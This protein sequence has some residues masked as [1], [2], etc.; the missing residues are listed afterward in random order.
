MEKPRGRVGDSIGFLGLLVSLLALSCGIVS[1][2]WATSARATC[3]ENKIDEEEIAWEHMDEAINEGQCECRYGQYTRQG[4]LVTLW[5]P[6][7]IIETVKDPYCMMSS[8]EN[9]GST[10][11]KQQGLLDQGAGLNS[12]T[13]SDTGAQEDHSVFQQVHI[14]LPDYIRQS[15]S[16]VDNRCYHSS[17]GNSMDYIS[18]D[19]AAWNDDTIAAATYPE[20]AMF[21]DLGMQELCRVDSVSSQVGLP[22]SILFW[23]MGAWGSTFP[24]SGHVNNDEYVTGNIAAAARAIYVGGRTGRIYDAASYYCYSGPMLLWIKHYFKLQPIR[25]TP[26]EYL[27]PIGLSSILWGSALND[28]VE[29]GDNFAWVLWRKRWCCDSQ[30]GS[31]F[32][33]HR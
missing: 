13:H 31:N 18:E 33:T 16:Q 10:T 25:P 8:G 3:C 19:D 29:C 32:N 7:R 23:C 9:N 24:M 15:I 5:E 14:I 27:I 12:G 20:T 26:R 28:D 22:N 17:V 2:L 6:V 21:A 4:T 30:G 1:I 11:G